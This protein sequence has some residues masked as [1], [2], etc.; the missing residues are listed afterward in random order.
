MIVHEF[1]DV[2]IL[3]VLAH[4][5]TDYALQGA[6]MDISKN[7]RTVTGKTMWRNALPAHCAI[8]AAGVVM[9]TFNPLI[10]VGEFIAHGLTDFLRTEGRYNFHID[11]AI[12][13]GT[14]L[15]WAGLASFYL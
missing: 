2:F 1:F 7:R 8:N 11:Q 3:L 6:V 5:I 13:I 10:G 14:K 12:H 9:I 4:F 15:I